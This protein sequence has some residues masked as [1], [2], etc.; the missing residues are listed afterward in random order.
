MISINRLGPENNHHCLIVPL[1]YRRA[2]RNEEGVLLNQS[3]QH[4]ILVSAFQSRAIL[5]VFMGCF[6]H[7]IG[8][9]SQAS[10]D[11]DLLISEYQYVINAIKD[12]G[13]LFGSVVDY[14]NR[15]NLI[16]DFVMDEYPDV[17]WGFPFWLDFIHVHIENQTIRFHHAGIFMC[18]YFDEDGFREI[19]HGHWKIIPLGN[20]P[21]ALQ[22]N[23]L[24]AKNP[25]TERSFF[26]DSCEVKIT[27]PGRILAVDKKLIDWVSIEDI[28]RF[29]S[30]PDAREGL[31]ALV[32]FYVSRH[33]ND[34]LPAF[35]ISIEEGPPSSQGDQ[36]S[37]LQIR[38]AGHG[39]I[40]TF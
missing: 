11:N 37:P 29:L 15:F 6:D 3:R 33:P 36:P 28:C 26:L 8:G 17:G 7:V 34:G 1:V 14:F 32:D 30:F 27:K 12:K 4:C 23:H 9:G 40:V 10:Y 21:L 13:F 24:S 2:C 18:F 31:N 39:D 19:I 20:S 5:G 38:T 25:H 35:L 22:Y 16:Y